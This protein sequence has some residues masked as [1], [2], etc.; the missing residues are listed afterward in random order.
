MAP[1]LFLLPSPQCTS[2]SLDH[3]NILIHH[4]TQMLS[5][6]GTP[7]IL[8]LRQ[9]NM[10]EEPEAPSFPRS[11]SSSAGLMRTWGPERRRVLARVIQGHMCLIL[12]ITTPKLKATV[13]QRRRW[14]PK[15][16]ALTPT[17]SPGLGD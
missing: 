9:N 2:T 13:A 4:P 11:L 7:K 8:S 15:P 10:A 12:G 16:A 17:S 1:Q 14:N 5:N 3:T 6:Q